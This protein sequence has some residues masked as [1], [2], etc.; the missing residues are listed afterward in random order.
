MNFK[1][2]HRNWASLISMCIKDMLAKHLGSY[3]KRGKMIYDK[4]YE[5]KKKSKKGSV[6]ATLKYIETKYRFKYFFCYYNS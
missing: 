3:C 2:S 5:S 1:V 6:E 4:F